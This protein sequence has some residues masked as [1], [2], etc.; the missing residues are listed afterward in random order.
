M[1]IKLLT[2]SALF[3]MASVAQAGTDS[4]AFTISAEIQSEC[5]IGSTSIVF[6]DA[7][8][9]KSN[10]FIQ[11]SGSFEINCTGEVPYS[12]SNMY[13]NMA[14]ADAFLLEGAPTTLTIK[15]YKDSAHAQVW[16]ANTPIT[17][18]S[19]N[20]VS[21]L[22]FYAR[23]TNTSPTKVLAVGDYSQVSNIVMSF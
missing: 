4:G 16:G 17:G 8:V 6:P 5:Q 20:G 23:A 1:K 2:A 14:G 21:N 19:T 7:T 3:A 22:P 15:F 11:A 9:L 18:T 12:I 10:E 13:N